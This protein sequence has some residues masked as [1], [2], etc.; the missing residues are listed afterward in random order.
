MLFANEF[1]PS[2]P[3]ENP[4]RHFSCVL[5]WF[6]CLI[7]PCLLS[8]CWIKVPYE[9]SLCEVWTAPSWWYKSNERLK[10]LCSLF[11]ACL[12]LHAHSDHGHFKVRL[13]S[14]ILPDP[15]PPDFPLS[16]DLLVPLLCHWGISFLL[17]H[18]GKYWE[19]ELE[20][21]EFLFHVS[22]WALFQP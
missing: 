7:L 15:W 18:C 14:S 2:N 21:I 16:S 11:C 20:L 22:G 8:C 10:A 19:F 6:F 17:S 12:S 13:G 4:S 5:V 9:H 3:E 1:V